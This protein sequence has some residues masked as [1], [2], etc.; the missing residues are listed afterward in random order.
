M[1]VYC[2]W[3]AKLTVLNNCA[4]VYG[5]FGENDLSHVFRRQISR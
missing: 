1:F 3:Y 5:A 2:T 4:G